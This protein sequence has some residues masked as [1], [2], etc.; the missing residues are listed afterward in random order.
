MTSIGGLGWSNTCL[1]CLHC[2]SL[3]QFHVKIV[4]NETDVSPKS[5]CVEAKVACMGRNLAHSFAIGTI[6]EGP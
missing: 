2:P 3:G 1:G 4:Q 5:T 6:C